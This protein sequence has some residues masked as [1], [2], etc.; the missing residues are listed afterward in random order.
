MHS[1]AIPTANLFS[2]AVEQTVSGFANRA[3]AAI[4]GFESDLQA[5]NGPGAQSF[6]SALQQKVTAQGAAPENSPL[7][8]QFSQIGS[9]L[10]AATGRHSDVSSS[11]DSRE[12][13]EE[14]D[15]FDAPTGAEGAAASADSNSCSAC[16]KALNA[17]QQTL[18]VRKYG[19]AL[20]PTCQ[21][22]RR[23]VE[24]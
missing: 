3:S 9:D 4:K 20:C 12:T 15:L 8:T 21:K 24:A 17:A 19:V 6:L 14:N 16:G 22:E 10:Q 18:S 2:N 23:A 11:R 7:A 13:H 5:G 1:L